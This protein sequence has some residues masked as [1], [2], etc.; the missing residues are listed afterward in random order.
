MPL[1]TIAAILVTNI[2]FKT[3]SNPYYVRKIVTCLSAAA[4]LGLG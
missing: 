1:A 2:C 4:V 3:D